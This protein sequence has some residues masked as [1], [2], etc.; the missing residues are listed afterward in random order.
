MS[1]L[2]IIFAQKGASF[3]VVLIRGRQTEL[4][5]QQTRRQTI[6]II[7]SFFSRLFTAADKFRRFPVSSDPV[8]LV[9]PPLFLFHRSPSVV[10]LL[11][12]SDLCKKKRALKMY[13]ECRFRYKTEHFPDKNSL[14]FRKNKEFL[15]G[16]KVFQEIR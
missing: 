15:R 13:A 14:F 3:L 12:L 5:S 6:T 2:F 4:Y 8:V 1:D 11:F 10:A 16:W 9:R 7:V